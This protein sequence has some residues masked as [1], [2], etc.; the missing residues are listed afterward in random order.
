MGS[1]QKSILEGLFE[2]GVRASVSCPFDVYVRQNAPLEMRNLRGS[3]RLRKKTALKYLRLRWAYSRM[4][5][6]VR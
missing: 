5:V 6:L 2:A 3:K 4:G 1:L